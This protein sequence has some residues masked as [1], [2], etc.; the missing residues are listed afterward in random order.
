MQDIELSGVSQG[1]WTDL[2][3]SSVG[4]VG[5]MPSHRR[6]T[7]T[8][9]TPPAQPLSFQLQCLLI[10]RFNLA[11]AGARSCEGARRMRRSRCAAAVCIVRW[12]SSCDVLAKMVPSHQ[13]IRLPSA[14]T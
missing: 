12:W 3:L 5:P 9:H 10:S 1:V 4:E 11:E 6:S 14:K 7:S 2:Q 13:I 8:A